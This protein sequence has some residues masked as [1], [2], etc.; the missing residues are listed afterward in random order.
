MSVE[1]SFVPQYRV[2]STLVPRFIGKQVRLVCRPIKL[3]ANGWTV[4]ACDGGEIMVTL[5]PDRLTTDTYFEVVGS[6]VNANTI[7]MFKSI[8]LGNMTLVNDTIGL[9]HDPRFFD[10]IFVGV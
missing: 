7:K 9:M 4:Q 5:Q 6:V 10:K 2:N 1:L 8:P 3:T